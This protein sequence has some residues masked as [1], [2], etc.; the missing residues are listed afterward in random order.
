MTAAG[1][2]L[3]DV[4]SWCTVKSVLPGLFKI[5]RQRREKKVNGFKQ[6]RPLEFLH[7][8]HVK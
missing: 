1:G 2:K 3:Q 6:N 7:F 8:I 4:S 5:E